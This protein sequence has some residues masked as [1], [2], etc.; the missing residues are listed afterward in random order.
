MTKYTIVV[1][2]LAVGTLLYGATAKAD[3]PQPPP[4]AFEACKDK[5]AGDACS[6]SFMGQSLKGTCI[7]LDKTLVCKPAGAPGM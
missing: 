5:Q 2:F 6:V 1:E 7:A 4:A 3:G